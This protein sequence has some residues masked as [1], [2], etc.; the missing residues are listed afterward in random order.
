[1]RPF[2][3][4]KKVK[5]ISVPPPFFPNHNVIFTFTSKSDP[6]H[7]RVSLKFKCSA[8]KLLR[9]R[10]F[11]VHHFAGKIF[12]CTYSKRHHSL[13]RD[14]DQP[15]VLLSRGF[16]VH[17]TV[18]ITENSVVDADIRSAK[19]TECKVQVVFFFF[20]FFFFFKLK[21]LSVN[22]EKLERKLKVFFAF[23]CTLYAAERCDSDMV[24]ELR[25]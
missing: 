12:I 18:N 21:F 4:K 20:F 7:E 8:T 9:Y 1:M 19:R 10:V 17:A 14:K 24:A 22:S 11:S 23:I 13:P 6:W 5:E 3:C 25:S 2:Q 16:S 15:L